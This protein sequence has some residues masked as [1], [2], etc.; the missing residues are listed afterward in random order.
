MVVMNYEQNYVMTFDIGTDTTN[1]KAH[2]TYLQTS[3]I[4]SYIRDSYSFG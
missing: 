2:T 1:D 4:K 3:L